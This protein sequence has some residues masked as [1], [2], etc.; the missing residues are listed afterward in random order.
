M[1]EVEIQTGLLAELV[2]FVFN[3][4]ERSHYNIYSSDGYCFYDSSQPEEID[5]ETKEVK[6]TYARVAYTPYKTIEE[7]NSVY[8]SVPI[9]EGFEIV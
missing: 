7:L 1:K 9:E 6:R 4:E 5:E 3:G 2:T 8:V